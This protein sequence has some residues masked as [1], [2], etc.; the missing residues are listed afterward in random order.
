MSKK[1]G[2]R[3]E[4]KQEDI[5]QGVVIADNFSNTF[6]RLNLSTANVSYI[7][8]GPYHSVSAHH[9]DNIDYLRDCGKSALI[10][11]IL[12]LFPPTNY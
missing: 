2:H 9:L 10:M 12:V 8:L 4:F 6:T 3:E 1:K 11:F 7:G 5:L